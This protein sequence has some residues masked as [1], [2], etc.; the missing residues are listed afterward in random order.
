MVLELPPLLFKG[1]ASFVGVGLGGDLRQSKASLFRDSG[2]VFFLVENSLVFCQICL[3]PGLFGSLI[4]L[5]G[6]QSLLI[7]FD[8]LLV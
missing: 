2:K 8:L 7:N 3:K 4:F 1:L 6:V 5:L